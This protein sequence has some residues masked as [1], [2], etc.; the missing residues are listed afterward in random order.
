MEQR[1]GAGS[2]EVGVATE[3]VKQVIQESNKVFVDLY[4]GRVL[5]QALVLQWNKP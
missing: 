3:L 5:V 4:D 1:Y 2:S